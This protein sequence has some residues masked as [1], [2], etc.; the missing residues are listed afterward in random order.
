MKVLSTHNT[1][2]DAVFRVATLLLLAVPCAS[3]LAR[4]PL[5]VD[6]YAGVDL[7]L[8]KTGRDDGSELDW[9]SHKSY[10][11]LSARAPVNDS[12][13]VLYN[14]EQEIAVADSHLDPESF[15]LGSHYVGIDGE[16]GT[17]RIGRFDSVLKVTV[18]S[19]ELFADGPGDLEPLLGV[20][21]HE[22]DALAYSSPDDRTLRF[23]VSV[24]GGDNGLARAYAGGAAWSKGAF[25]IAMST[26]QG[27]ANGAVDMGRLLVQW[28][29]RSWQLSLLREIEDRETGSTAATA[30]S[31]LIDIGNLDF[32]LQH[33]ESDIRAS[34]E[35]R[36]V[37][38]VGY[39]VL[40]NWWFYCYLVRDQGGHY[41]NSQRHLV[42]GVRYAFE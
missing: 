22:G 10:L 23:D 20:Q 29:A 27:L 42:A 32:R 33:V 24:L 6:M 25:Q 31:L 8:Q 36:S 4:A 13:D 1:G 14:V 41:S 34:G 35:R 21:A 40:S 17:L 11:G 9:L 12:Y 16:L 3:A 15:A 26:E 39:S 2:C 28:Q 5:E 19:M 37:A 18:D 38:G 30:A 7:A